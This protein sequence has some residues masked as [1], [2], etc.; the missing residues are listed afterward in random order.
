[1]F[2]LF[3]YFSTL[4]TALK[5]CFNTPSSLQSS[6]IPVNQKPPK[7]LPPPPTK[8]MSYTKKPTK[9]KQRNKQRKTK[10]KK[11]T[12]KKQTNRQTDKQT[13]NNTQR[14]TT[15]KTSPSPAVF[16]FLSALRSHTVQLASSRTL[17]AWL[18][19]VPVAG[20]DFVRKISRKH[21]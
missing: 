1:M 5:N 16:G 4:K 11:T 17:G 18:K 10:P 20:V 13:K 7:T 2:P 3:F 9:K 21:L 6:H 14:K 19:G 15:T 8:K 12:K